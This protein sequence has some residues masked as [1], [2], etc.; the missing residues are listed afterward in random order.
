MIGLHASFTASDDTLRQI[1]E[2]GAPVHV[3]VAEGAVDQR[4]ARDRGYASVVERLDEHGILKPDTILAHGVHLSDEE[5]LI[6]IER[7]CWF[8]HN[9]TSNRNNR[10]GYAKPTRFGARCG[11]GTDGIGAD[12]F[13]AARDLFFEA[14][15]ERHDVDVAA[16]LAANGAMASSLL[17]VK[18][19]TLEVGAQADIVQLSYDPAAPLQQ[20]NLIGHLLFGFSASDV[21]HVWVQGEQVVRNGQL[22]R[23][24]HENLMA[25]SR[26]VA[27][28]LWRRYLVELER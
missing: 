13:A 27:S 3:H 21:E 28:D 7:G 20:E 12:M 22:L 18:L 16:F 2:V 4:D 24:D 1:A 10:V 9:P 11:V 8:V 5:V 15:K 6:A 26:E 19:G 25:E 14:R 23:V 17:G